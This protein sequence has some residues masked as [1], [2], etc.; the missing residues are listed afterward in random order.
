MASSASAAWAA[1]QPAGFASRGRLVTSLYDVTRPWWARRSGACRCGM[2][3]IATLRPA[4][5]PDIR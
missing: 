5:R 3:E 1:L 4:E 2:D